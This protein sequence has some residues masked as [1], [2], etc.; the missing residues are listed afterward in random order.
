MNRSSRKI[1]I[2]WGWEEVHF[3]K[4]HPTQKKHSPGC[5]GKC[6]REIAGH[7]RLKAPLPAA[8]GVSG[9][10][11]SLVQR[12]IVGGLEKAKRTHAAGL[13]RWFR[14]LGEEAHSFPE[15]PVTSKHQPTCFFLL[16]RNATFTG[17]AFRCA[18]FPPDFFFIWVVSITSLDFFCYLYLF[19]LF[20][21]NPFC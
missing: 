19:P 13:Q 7:L 11:Q 14:H 6:P 10:A 5:R 4:T 8:S 12:A 20:A 18:V 2:Q 21:F 3:L 9:V 1:P 15:S 16:R 17:L